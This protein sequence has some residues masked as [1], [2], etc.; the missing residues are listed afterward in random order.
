M[1]NVKTYIGDLEKSNGKY[2]KIGSK[3]T[4]TWKSLGKKKRIQRSIR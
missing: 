1:V 4:Q 2:L 3:I